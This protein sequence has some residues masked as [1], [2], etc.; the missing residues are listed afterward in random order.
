[1]REQHCR[2]VRVR[3]QRTLR[4]AEADDRDGDHCERY[5]HHQ[6]FS[7]TLRVEKVRDQQEVT[8]KHDRGRIAVRP[9]LHQLQP[10]KEEQQHNGR[11]PPEHRPVLRPDADHGSERDRE[12]QPARRQRLAP[13]ERERAPAIERDRKTREPPRRAD[14]MRRPDDCKCEDEPGKILPRQQADFRRKR[15]RSTHD[16]SYNARACRHCA[17]CASPRASSISVPGIR[18]A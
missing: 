17:R 18:S 10:G 16:A 12:Q 1:V 3:S 13:D 15:M 8:K 11:N 7:N 4:R 5:A 14:C 2:R 6:R 9:R